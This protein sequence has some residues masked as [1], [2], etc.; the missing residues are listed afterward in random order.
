V[1]IKPLVSI[2]TSRLVNP[3]QSGLLAIMLDYMKLLEDFVLPLVKE[4][5]GDEKVA[6]LKIGYQLEHLS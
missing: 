4:D 1:F 5:V 3:K 6:E 2:A